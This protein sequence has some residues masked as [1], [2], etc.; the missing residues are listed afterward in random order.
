MESKLKD[1][2]SVM[3]QSWTVNA[4]SVKLDKSRIY[5]TLVQ[6]Y[7]FSHSTGVVGKQ[8]G[9]RVLLYVDGQLIQDPFQTFLGMG[10]P[11]FERVKHTH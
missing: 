10:L 7:P 8:Q 9:E 5:S 6:W 11:F 2:R 3:G 4:S 1:F